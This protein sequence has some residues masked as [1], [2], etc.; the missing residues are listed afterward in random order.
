M[1][2]DIFL[3]KNFSL[4]FFAVTIYKKDTKRNFSHMGG[5]L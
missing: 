4:A 2:T 5:E 1:V 3:V